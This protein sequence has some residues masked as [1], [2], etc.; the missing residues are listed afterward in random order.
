MVGQIKHHLYRKRG[1]Y[2]FCRRVPKTL[3]E[4]YPKPRIVVAL[5]TRHFRDALRQSQI[6]TTCLDD[7]WFHM[8]LDAMGLYNVQTKIFQP[9]KPNA[10][11]MS[12][13][14]AFYVRLKGDRKDK[15]FVRAAERNSSCVIDVLGDRPINAYSS[16]EAGKLRDVLINRGLAVSSIKRM[17]GSIKAIINLSMAEYGIDDRNPFSSIYMPD[18]QPEERQPIPLSCIRQL[19]RDCAEIDDEKR[20]LL[21]IISDTGMRLSE[22]VGLLKENIIL[23]DSIPHVIIQSHPWRSLKTKGSARVVPLVGAALWAS[24]RLIEGDSSY[25]FP[26]YCSHAGCKANS[27]SG[28]LNKWLKPRVTGNGVVHSFRHSM[29][30]RLRAVECPSDVIDQIG[31]WSS[32][33]VGSS[34]GNGYE[35]PVLFKWMKMLEE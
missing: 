16:S 8:Q 22:A 30:D 24:R 6:L 33:T 31:G 1:F 9:V 25:A 4:H 18:E 11:L 12:E 34:Y 23:D 19:Q 3:L 26:S 17:F 2:Y 5:K 21:A 14:A 27:A 13:A 32:G 10:P 7:Q 29:R 28:A 35:L 15:V 20:W